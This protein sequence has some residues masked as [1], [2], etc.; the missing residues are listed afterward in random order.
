MLI[1]NC[2]KEMKT[3]ERT[4]SEVNKNES[5]EKSRNG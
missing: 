1:Y 3:L 2:Q 5:N 4:K